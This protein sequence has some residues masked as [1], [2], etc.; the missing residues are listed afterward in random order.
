MREG[1][2]PTIYIV[3]DEKAVLK[4]MERLI[5]SLGM[6]VE[7][8]SSGEEFLNAEFRNRNACLIVDAKMPG[9]GG[10]DIHRELKA[11]SS[12]LPVIL[13]TAFDSDEVRRKAKKAGIAGY[14]KK[15]V[16]DQALLDSIQ[17]VLSNQFPR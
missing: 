3:D 11:R 5:R 12:D 16:D 7:T 15:P 10:L 9:M 17:W 2:K 13:I 14:F 8:F 6:N 1:T 4:A